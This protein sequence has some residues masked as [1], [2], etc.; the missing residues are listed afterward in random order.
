MSYNDCLIEQAEQVRQRTMESRQLSAAVAAIKE[1]GV[2][3]DQRIERRVARPASL[4]RLPAFGATQTTYNN[5]AL[6]FQQVV[7]LPPHAIDL[8]RVENRRQPSRH[9]DR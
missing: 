2:L 3:S 8:R 5:L 1:M 7:G 4:M 6:D 9:H